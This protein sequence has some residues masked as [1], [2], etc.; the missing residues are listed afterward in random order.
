MTCQIIKGPSEELPVLVILLGPDEDA[1]TLLEALGKDAGRATFVLIRPSDWNTDLSPWYA[2]PLRK[3]GDAFPGGA[4]AFLEE[5]TET[6]ITPLERQLHGTPAWYGIAGYS[7]AGLFAIYSLYR[8]TMFSRAASVSGS[9]WYDGFPEYCGSHSP[10]GNVTDVYFSLGSKE[11]RAK[12]PR[13][14]KVEDS[15]RAIFSHMKEDGIET[16]FEINPGN[17]FQDPCGRMAKGIRWLLR[18]KTK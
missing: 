11:S 14:A 6:V 8:T 3:D 4:E 16:V 9:L 12:N 17:H 13:M 5:L 18:N 1:G 7:M 10:A 15:T 2:L